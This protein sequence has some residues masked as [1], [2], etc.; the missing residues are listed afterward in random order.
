MI[1]HLNSVVG[2]RFKPDAKAST[3]NISG[4]LSDG[5][6]VKVLKLVIDYKACEWLNDPKMAQFLR[7]STLFGTEKFN[8]YLIAAKQA[9]RGTTKGNATNGSR[10]GWQDSL[11]SLCVSSQK[12]I[13][14]YSH[15]LA[16]TVNNQISTMYVVHWPSWLNRFKTE[17]IQGHFLAEITLLLAKNEVSE[18][19][20]Q[21]AISVAPGRK[22]YPYPAPFDWLEMCKEQVSTGLPSVDEVYK[23]LEQYWM[24]RRDPDL[25]KNHKWNHDV[26]L[27]IMQTVK[28][29]FYQKNLG[30][31]DLKLRIRR[32]LSLW[33]KH[34]EE[35]GKVTPHVKQLP[36]P[37][38]KIPTIAEQLGLNANVPAAMQARIDAM[39]QNKCA[40]QAPIEKIISKRK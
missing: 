20:L 27:W 39:K 4:R 10:S 7:P 13:S 5:A 24:V 2:S 14:D 6:S 12:P 15:T 37:A 18:Q 32:E 11:D 34:V 26:S 40:Y 17:D 36:R 23:E 35:G 19:Q 25:L 21:A 29:D 22:F 28:D 30:P 38:L 8:G 3:K 33:E 1:D 31:S 9:I 16:M